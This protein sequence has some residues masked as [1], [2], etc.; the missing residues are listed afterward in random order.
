MRP[1][2]PAP[3]SGPVKGVANVEM[4]G[5]DEKGDN[6]DDDGTVDESDDASL[7]ANSAARSTVSSWTRAS[8]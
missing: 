6:L 4:T 1:N 5:I 7:R 3:D 2:R 8:L